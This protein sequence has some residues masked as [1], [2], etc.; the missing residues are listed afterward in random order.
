MNGV[1]LT[2]AQWKR[3]LLIAA[4]FAFAALTAGEAFAQTVTVRGNHRI[5]SETIQSYFAVSPGEHLDQARVDRGVRDMLATGLFSS[6]HASRSGNGVLVN[7]SENAIVNRVTFEGN[8]KVKTELLT[9]ELQTRSRG[10]FSQGQVDADV[11]RIRE[12]Y[13]RSGRSAASVSARLSDGGNGRTNVT[14]VINEGS[15]TGVKSIDFVGNH[16]FSGSR[17]RGVMT[18]TESNWLSWLKSSDVYDPDKVASDLELIRRYYLKHGYADFRVVGSDVHLD[19]A[20]NGYIITITV[21]EG[22]KYRISSVNVESRIPDVDP[23]ALKGAVEASSGSVYNAEAV[24]KSV[25]GINKRVAA[26]GYAF[27]QVQPRGERDSANRTIALDF[28]VDQ[29]PRV[30]IERINIR[31]NTRTRDYV[32][33]REFDLGEGDAYNRVLIDKAERRLKNLGYF[34]TVKI[35]NEPGSAPDRVIVNVDVED[36]AT[37][38]F[39]ISGGYS[40]S[41][42]FIAEAAVT[43]KNFLGR[44]QYAR[45]AVSG[46]QRSRGVELNFT[47]PYFMGQRLA[48]GF[49]LFSK[50]NDNT[51]TAYYDTRSTGINLRVALPIDDYFTVG[52]RYSLY[53][54]KLSIPNSNSDNNYRPYN[55]CTFPSNTTYG[56]CLGNGEASL[57]IKEARGTTLT[58]LVGLSFI[59]NTRDN[60]QN[61]TEGYYIDVRPD[62]AG[63][64]GDSKFGRIVGDAKFYYP[65][66]EDV[67]AMAHVQGGYIAP[68]SGKLRELDHFFMGPSLVR[69]FAPAGIGPR[70]TS[71]DARNNPIGAT[72]YFGASLET[73]FPIW[74]LPRELG[75]K[76]A[77]FADAGTAFGYN[78]RKDFTGY[79][80]PVGI[81][82]YTNPSTAASVSFSCSG[83]TVTAPDLLGNAQQ[84]QGS[85]LQ[86][87]DSHIIRSSVGASIL[88][89]SPLGP[90]RFDFAQAITKDRYDRTQFFR[91][92]GGTTF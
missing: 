28:V 31:G 32:I 65:I 59:Y 77:L 8:S 33:R 5:E 85:Y 45:I 1:L 34:K 57:A 15:K 78:G 43:E 53:Q 25:E 61:P 19:Q 60:D 20:S 9:G 83:A 13:R 90:I 89:Q 39:S 47:E 69:G 52:A 64:G 88:W 74:G 24:E 71:Y 51:R 68:F 4:I 41:D 87:H 50:Y 75:L 26:R 7:V 27:A 18:T 38:A 42:G 86:V 22:E 14:F 16:A 84:C 92:S 48:A 40:T 76:A 23:A 2:L 72:T 56:N 62:V 21:D 10:P 58:S 73:Q 54:T 6:V 36:Q 29:G 67:V 63:L 11:E 80:S 70:D 35:T 91:F 66:W 44:G 79:G 82:T 49:D 46:G 55:D 12:V 30:Y 81:Q 17:L 37:G 3:A